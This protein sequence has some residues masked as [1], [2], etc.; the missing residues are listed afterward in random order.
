MALA[1]RKTP[2]KIYDIQAHNGK[3]SCL[4]IGETGRVLV[5]GGQDRNV[6]LWTLGSK[7]CFM[8]LTGHNSAIDC[9]KF[10]YSDDFVYSADDTGVIKR[11]DLNSG[12]EY[13]TFFGHMKTVRTLD[14]HPYS[15]YVVS[16]SH[17][18][19]IR[20]WDV[21]EKVCIKRYRGHIS[22]VN[23]V[24]FSPDGLW[25]ASAGTEGCVIIWDIRMSKQFMEFTERE[26][27]AICVQYHPSDL[28]MAAGRNDGSVD[29]YDL[30]KKQLI[31][32]TDKTHSKG[33]TVKCITF[34][35]GGRCLFVG[36]AAGISIVGWEPD[37]EFD[38]VESS[39]TFLGDMQ[40]T[41]KEL[42][43]GSYENRNV[44]IHAM[45]LSHLKPFYN[46]KNQPFNH[47]QSSR[48]SFSKGSGKLRLSI[49]DRMLSSDA[50]EGNSNGGMSPNLSIE[51]IDEEEGSVHVEPKTFDFSHSNG[52]GGTNSNFDS[53]TPPSSS[54]AV[55][56]V[57]PPVPLVNSNYLVKEEMKMYNISSSTG[58]SSDLDYYPCKNN[59][60][61]AEKEDFRVEKAQPPD[62]A[63]KL[64]TGN[65]STV[66]NSSNNIGNTTSTLPTSSRST[67]M[68]QK[69][70]SINN[71][72]SLAAQRRPSQP[73]LVAAARAAA[74]SL[75][76][77]I[78]TSRSTLELNK[79]AAEEQVTFKKP[80]SRG[81][82][83]IR[84]NSSLG[85]KIRKSESSA[86]INNMKNSTNRYSMSGLGGSGGNSS[87]HNANIKVEIVT[88]PV[89]SKT[90]LDMRHRNT[91]NGDNHHHNSNSA[92]MN[93][94]GII[95]YNNGNNSNNNNSMSSGTGHSLSHIGISDG[96]GGGLL[97]RDSLMMPPPSGIPT[98]MH[99]H[100]VPVIR[101]VG[102]D[103]MRGSGGDGI[104]IINRGLSTN[105]EYEIQL[106]MNEHDSVFQ[107]LCNRTA[108]LATIRNYTQSGDMSMAMKIAIRMNDPH[109]M[110]DLF[111]A[112]LEK[113][114]NISLDMCVLVLPKIY[115]LLQSEYKFHCTRACDM[116]RV[117]LTTF[118][119]VIREN[120][121]PWGA[122]TIGVDVSREERVSKC[123]ECKTWLLR[124]RTL[125]ENPKIGT[126]LQQL[127]NMMV[128][129]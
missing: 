51:M 25:I 21:R 50:M 114:A 124:I 64:T 126:N 77:R 17:D 18:T 87:Q 41:S 7:E 76:R 96:G 67:L 22:H 2:S 123:M 60:S 127:Q 36:T 59:A 8:S 61:D 115:D 93:R 79:L 81:S 82:S 65:N 72:S 20:L 112:I 26:S 10:A 121:D 48:K 27:P 73:N 47:N 89:R 91:S 3:V 9:V 52:S 101:F 24:K 38:H 16:G 42:I 116:L 84:N 34:D 98:A 23:S 71:S 90:S 43:C 45:K 33:H 37:Q 108:L 80:I 12:T 66:L 11:W 5:T 100:P 102:H 70:D 54:I 49:G 28:L 99:H 4:D 107:A 86:Q 103:G 110:V 95:H 57:P 94:A 118:L 31:S 15:E 78:S 56:N 75:T 44:A 29:L 68:R 88:K 105:E 1:A 13:T 53:Y 32:R 104:G 35:E 40:V 129:L 122:C 97:D 74:S 106:L 14:F 63:P 30:E 55:S 6:N 85:S 46:P 58:Y 111:G 39:W 69:T 109:V 92:T 113:T 62:Y 120:T 117:I 19:S 83:P 119:V 125:P 128:D